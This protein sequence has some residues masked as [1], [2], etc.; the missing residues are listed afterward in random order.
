[1]CNVLLSSP[2]YYYYYYLTEVGG[3]CT[4]RL[5]EIFRTDRVRCTCNKLPNLV[6]SWVP[7][8]CCRSSLI[9]VRIMPLSLK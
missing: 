3:L 7:I 1:M 2:K 4:F 9:F 6:S 5:S 8:H